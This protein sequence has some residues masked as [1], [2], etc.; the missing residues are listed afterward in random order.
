MAEDRYLQNRQKVYDLLKTEG[1]T[2]EELGGSAENLFKDKSNGE[3]AYKALTDAGYDDLGEYSDFQSMLFAP[4]NEAE[5]ATPS[6]PAPEAEGD[7]NFD[8]EPNGLKE[9]RAREERLARQQA[10][11]EG[12]DMFNDMRQRKAQ[13]AVEQAP[14]SSVEDAP[15]ETRQKYA[16][17]EAAIKDFGRIS[18]EIDGFDQRLAAFNEKSDQVSSGK[19]KLSQDEFKKMQDEGKALADIA[20]RYDTVMSSAEGQEYKA[21]SERM[22]EIAKGEKTPESAWEYAQE[23][24]KLQRNPVFRAAQGENAA[25]EDEINAGLLQGQIAYLDEKMKSAKGNE[26][27][28]LKKAFSDAKEALYANP[29]YRKEIEGKIAENKLE[30]EQIGAQ[31]AAF[32][33]Q[34]R[35]GYA[36]Q[37]IDPNYYWQMEKGEPELQR[38]DAAARMHDDAIREYEKPT[39]YEDY[40]KNVGKGL[41]DWASNPDTYSFGLQSFADD[42]AVVRPVLEK[43]EKIAGSV[44]EDAIM[45][46]GAIDSLEKQLTPGELAVLDA[47]FEKVG[48]VAAKGADTAIGYQIGQGIGDM[49][50]LGLEMIA[51]SG[52]GTAVRKGIDK[53]GMSMMKRMMGKRLYR[54][55]AKSGAGRVALWGT[56]KI[57]RDIAETAV[58]MP[59]MPSTYKNLGEKAVTLDEGYKT[60]SFKEYA[61][62]AAWDQFVEQLTEVS[63]GFAFPLMGKVV[64][65]PG[66]QKLFKETIGE[67]GVR[68]LRSFMERGDIKLLDDAML[69]SF[70]GEWEEEL[71]GAVIHS[72]TDDP[73]ALSDFFSAEQQLVLLGT[74]APLPISRGAVGGVQ[75]AVPTANA[76]YRW[77]RAEAELKRLGLDEG[78]ISRLK[79]VIDNAPVPEAAREVMN[80][81][82]D[83]YEGMWEAEDAAE[84]DILH[85]TLRAADVGPSSRD[86]D[87]NSR[88]I[89]GELARYFWAAQQKRAAGLMGEIQADQKVA[90]K[91]TELEQNLGGTFYH[92]LNGEDVVEIGTLTAP[93]G[94]TRNIYITSE[95]VNS[96]GELAYVGEDGSKGFVNPNELGDSRVIPVDRYLAGLVMQDAQEQEA[97]GV[98]N[99]AVAVNQSLR[100]QVESLEEVTYQGQTGTISRASSSDEAAVFIPD[101]GENVVVPWEELASQNGIPVPEIVTQEENAALG[102]DAVVQR[103]A[104]QQQIADAFHEAYSSANRPGAFIDTDE[105]RMAV[106]DIIED[107][108]NPEDG[109]AEFTVRQP[110]GTRNVTMRTSI[111]RVM[112][113]LQGQPVPAEEPAPAPAEEPVAEQPAE[114]PEE[115]APKIPVDKNGEKI[116]DAPGVSVE[117]AL[118]DIY[119][120]EGITEEMADEYIRD[121]AAEAEKGRNPKRGKMNLAEWGKATAEANRK[122]DFWKEMR[123]FADAN[124]AEREREQKEEAERQERI[125]QY[126]VDPATFDMTPQT[127]EEA[128]AEYLGNSEKLIDLDDAIR[129]TLG[130]RKDNRVPRELFRHLGNGGILVKNGG[131]SVQD[132]A[133]DI[134][135]EYE[136]TLA[137]TQDDV[138]TAI[139]DALL[140]KTKTEMRETIFNN[141]LEEARNAAEAAEA[142]PVEEPAPAPVV[143]EPEPEPTP[144][145]EPQ[146]EPVSEP[147]APAEE[148]AE[149]PVEEPEPAE[150]ETTE[151]PENKPDKGRKSG[152]K[153]VSLN[154]P[155]SPSEITS[156]EEARAYFENL[157]GKGKRADNSVRVWELTHKKKSAPANTEGE[158]SRMAMS[159]V[160]ESG[161]S[162]EEASELVTLGTQLAEDYITE[163][164]LVKFPQFFKNL[165]ETFGDGIRP[166]SKQIYLG[167]SA[168]VSDELADQMDD[169]KAVRAFDTSIDL[170]E[171]SDEQDITDIREGEQPVEDMVGDS[172]EGAG[173]E[174]VTDGSDGD[175]TGDTGEDSTP[176]GSESADSEG[177]VGEV[178]G[179][180]GNPG[181]SDYAPGN[182]EGDN[183]GA[184]DRGGSRRG[185]KR[186]GGRR[187]RTSE[188]VGESEPGLGRDTDRVEDTEAAA[189]EAEQKAYDEEKESIKEETDT[190]KLKSRKDDLK[191]K[192]SAIAEKV[193][194]EKAKLSGQLRAVIERLRELFSTSAKKS[195]ALAQE[196]VPYSSASDP[197][198]EHAIGSVVPSGSADAMRDAIRRLEAEEG[199]SVAE[200]VKDELGYASLDEMFSSET[201]NE[202]LSA[203]QVDSVGLAIHQMKKGKMFIIGDMTGIGKGRQGAALIR[204]SKRQG[205]K[206]LFV[207]EKPD[208]FSD[209][210][211]DLADI[212]TK[213][214]L[215]WIVNSDSGANITD[216]NSEDK[217]VL[218]K[219]PGKAESDSLY[220]SDSD[221]L[222]TVK[223]GLYKGKQYDFVM[224]TYSQAQ[225]A[226]TTAAER[227][228]DWIKKYAKDAIV[229]CDESHNASGD[230]NRGKYFQDIVKN[231]QGVTFSSATFAKR[232]DNMV[233][234]ALRSSIGDAQMTQEDMIKA[235]QQYGIPMQEI[236][237]ASLFKTGEMVRRERDF[238]D[239]KTHW[240]EPKEIYSEEE[241]GRSRQTFDKSI[242]VVNDIIDFQRRVVD[243]IIKKKNEDEFK[244]KNEL[245]A[246]ALATT[247]EGTFYEYTTTP[248]S[249]QVS[250]VA[251][252]MFY[253]IKA[254]KAADMAIEQIKKGEKPVIAVENTLESY[255]KDIDGDVKSADFAFVLNRGLNTALK[256]RLKV[257]T[258]RF[259]P[260]TK[261]IEVVKEKSY[262]KELGS[263]EPYFGEPAQASLDAVKASLEQYSEDK[264]VMP[265]MLSPIDYIKKRIEDAGYK[266]GEITGRS[267]QLVQAPDG[268]WH[269]EPYKTDKK[270]AISQF[271]G[272]ETDALILNT[273][274]STGISLH[275][276]RR[277]KDQKKRN[278]IILQPA[279]DPNT[280]VQIRG[281]VDRTG[282]VSRAEYFY[283]TSPIPAEQKVIMMLRQKLASLDANSVGTENVSSN[284]VNADDMDNKYGD[285][286]ARQFL[287][288][289][290]EINDQLD[291]PLQEKKG[292]YEHR[293]GLLYQLLIGI[294]RMTCEEQEMILGELQSAYRDQIEY[295]NQNGIND[296]ATTTMNL[297]AVTIDKGLFIKGKDNESMS[298][299]AHDT[300]IE[301]VEVNVLNKPLR[302][303]DINA[304]MKKLGALTEDGKI[305]SEYGT[306]MVDLARAYIAKAKEERQAK[307]AAA[308]RKLEQ[309]LREQYPKPELQSEAD[310]EK[311]I[312]SMP[313]YAALL[314]K[315]Q[316]DYERFSAELDRQSRGVF[317][318]ARY[319]KPGMPMLVP[320]T[321]DVKENA[322]MSYGRF[323]GF[324]I[325]KDGKPK[326]I[327]AV[328]AV[329]DSRASIEIPIISKGD[330]MQS[331]ID[332]TYGSFG[333]GGTN[334]RD[335]GGPA[336]DSSITDEDRR[337][338]RDEWWDK[339]IPKDTNR[340]IRYMVTGNILQACGSLGK[341]KGTITTF[342]R[343]DP[344]TGEITVERGMLLAED[345]DPENFEVRSAVTKEDVWDGYDQ[346]KDEITNI[347]VRREGDKMIVTFDRK[348][349]EKLANHPIMK[350]DGFKA[351][352]DGGEI[353]PYSRDQLRAYVSEGNVEAVLDYLYKNYSFTKGHQFVMPDSTE[354]V[355]AI[356]YTD[357]PYKDVIDEFGTKYNASE[358][359]VESRIKKAVQQY[360]M[361]VNNE[362]LKTKI[363]EL[364]QLRQAYYRK[365]YAKDESSRL[366][367]NV[368]IYDQRIEQA[369]DD[370]DMRDEAYAIR[371]AIKEELAERGV[372]GNAMH[373]ESGKVPIDTIIKTFNDLN[374]NKANADLAKRIFA[375]VKKLKLDVIFNEKIHN[376][377]GGQTAGQ[378]V[379]YNWKYMNAE[380]ITDQMKADTILHELVHT[381]T[382]Y[383]KRLVDG[384]YEHLINQD[385]V[386]AVQQLD[387]IYRQIR[388][389]KNFTHQINENGD[390]YTDY[391]VQ[392]W[393]EMM[394]EAGSNENFRDD[395]KRTTLGVKV[396]SGIISF[397]DVTN[398]TDYTGKTQSAYDAIKERLDVLIDNFSEHGFT[399]FFRGSM[400]GER[401]Y[402]E[403]YRSGENLFNPIDRARA[404]TTIDGIAKK[405]GVE[406][407]QDSSLNA[408]GAFNP[409]TGKIR[410][411]IDAHKDTAD[412][413]ATLLHEA[414]AHYG[415]RKLFGKDWRALRSRLYEQASPEIKAKVD[416]IAKAD[417]LSTEVAMEEYIAQ[418]AEDGRF[419]AQE[420]SFWQRIV[421]AIKRLLAKIGV[422]AGYLTD[423]DFRA[424]LYASYRNLE[425]RGAIEQAQ[426]VAAYRA[427]RMSADLSR[428]NANFV[429]NRR[430]DR[431]RTSKSA[432]DLL[433]REDDL[434]GVS[435]GVPG[436][437]E[438]LERNEDFRGI[439][440]LEERLRVL[441]GELGGGRESADGGRADDNRD[442]GGGAELENRREAISNALIEAAKESGQYIDYSEIRK[443]RKDL[444]FGHTMES[445]VYYDAENDR[446][447][448]VRNPFASARLTGND[449]F[450]ILFH[451]IIHN[452]YFPTERYEFLGITQVPYARYASIVLAQKSAGKNAKPSTWKD[453]HKWYKD[454]G[455]VDGGIDQRCV[456]WF[457]KDGILVCDLGSK[458]LLVDANGELHPIDPIIRF[459]DDPLDIIG[460]EDDMLNRNLSD[461]PEETRDLAVE[462]ETGE[463]YRRARSNATALTAAEAYNSNVRTVRQALHEVVVDEYAPVDTLVKA[464]ADESGRKIKDNERV[465]DHLREVGGKAMGAIRSYNEKFL[466]PMWDA[467][468]SFRKAAGDISIEDT[469][470]YIGL[471]SGLERNEVFAKR[472]AK[473][474]Y[475]QQYE[476]AID[477]INAEEKEK[478][479]ALDK[480]LKTGAISDVTY[481]GELT[482]LQQEMN[483]KRDQAAA[484]RDAHIA[485]VDAGTDERYAEYR[486][487]D[488][489]AITAWAET[490]DVAAA[491]QAASDFVNDMEQRAGASVVKEMWKRINAATKETLKFQYE[492]D[493][494]TRDQYRDISKMLNYYVPMRGFAEDTAEDLFN[495]YVTAQSNDFQP[496]ILSA[497]G[498]HTMYEGPLGNIGAMHSSA[499]SQGMKNQAKLSLLNLVRNRKG[500]TIATITRA[501]FVK[502]GQKD[503]AGKDIYEVAYPDVPENATFQQRQSIIEQFEED[504]KQLKAQGDAYNAHREVDLH[505][506]VVAFEKESHKNEHIVQVREGGK[507]YGIIINGNPA[508]AQAING[509]RRGNGAG[510][511]FLG[512][513]RNWTRML[514]QMFTT[515]SVP[516]WV[517]NFQ[518]DFGQGLTNTFIRNDK[519]YFGKYLVNYARAFKVFPL[520]IG[521]NTMDNAL[522]KGDSVAQLYQQYL[523]N[524]GPMG[525]TRLEDNEYFERQ[526]KRYLD[527]S[528][529]TG[530]IKGATG[531]LEAIG[532]V[533]EAVE[534]VTRFAV[535]MTSMQ[536]GRPLH[537]SIADAK[538][539]ST[540]FARKGSGR[541]FTKDELD[542]MRRADGRPLNS[543]EK[544]FVNAVSI[545]VEIF[546]ATVPFFN[547]A[548][549][550]LE[551]KGV[552]YSGNF[553]KTL[554]ADSIYFMA[555]LG[556]MLLR[557]DDGGDDDKEKYSHTS[558]YLRRNN[559]LFGLGDGLYAKWALPQEYR[560]CYA[561]GDIVGSAIKQQRPIDDLAIDAFGALMQLSPTGVISDEVLFSAGDKQKAWENL[562]VGISPGVVAPVFEAIFNRD[563]KGARL[564]N[565][566]FN[567]NNR[568]YPGWTK[569]LNTTGEEYVKAAETL[570]KLQRNSIEGLHIADDAQNRVERGLVNLNPA[571]VEHLVESYFSG[572]YQII[573]RT[574]EAIGKAVGGE[575]KVR[576]I[577][578]LNRLLL[579]A[580][581]NKRD[582]YY[583]NMYYYFK[584]LDTEASRIYSEYLKT[585]PAHAKEMMGTKDYQYMLIFK[586][587]DMKEKLYRKRGKTAENEG[588]I[589]TKNQ[590]DE[591]IQSLHEQIAKEC[592]DIYFGRQEV[593]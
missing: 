288:D 378:L 328:F 322:P 478:K 174:S 330:V 426:R 179:D 142:A 269:T 76:A 449:D 347:G 53:A 283:I 301:R 335:I 113:G 214:L 240:Y 57:G 432:N 264:E 118:E 99:E 25:S 285:E 88:R 310:Y 233:L 267:L 491:E 5:Q 593:K 442:Y 70:G 574:P 417:G 69:G 308:E 255:L 520:I 504:M 208:L 182:G 377:V 493:M 84:N 309:E 546:R 11:S 573:V 218:V 128:V 539:V 494:L 213:D 466:R 314:A 532:R 339:M 453:M 357:K 259:N 373:F 349:R 355:D 181:E 287:I 110:D 40:D 188:P 457:K 112:A 224:M 260:E 210:Y 160:S 133:N 321:D 455:F 38:L 437:A 34:L 77:N 467:V 500:N 50:T 436:Y 461:L 63:N 399:E 232:P 552:N 122:A 107:T 529:K 550:G 578:L 119:T 366:A 317:N 290:P 138:R 411:N 277:F 353:D 90:A 72:V 238:S 60:R 501:W 1:Y 511:R 6:T 571:I 384:G 344:D 381:V 480:Q 418:L 579:N 531:V 352:I 78:R 506:G 447:I 430:N 350:D 200:F 469:E 397:S 420:E 313:Q 348:G 488:Y 183:G 458:N 306:K 244:E 401:S 212:G 474:D 363:R 80:A 522:A 412:L 68:A 250:N 73:K 415:L 410:I 276:S 395:L 253:S 42:V 342:T 155:G 137:I 540:N 398:R 376:S 503:A 487:K 372:H 434:R 286:I 14:T 43:V 515:F 273:A 390:S 483:D 82:R 173:E 197:T 386:D 49:V 295:L 499:I 549:Q 460:P 451:H 105:G 452:L 52:A 37:G 293:E 36:E 375:L 393:F 144:E 64:K 538:E 462:Q 278:M 291:K 164:G 338:A 541:S 391:G 16:D 148:P 175:N 302:S 431:E 86:Y 445:D 396:M 96:N 561:L 178:S 492:H 257:T 223:R 56:H 251:G 558:D 334:L 590:M 296:L 428:N 507:E 2:D 575:A 472:D 39:K 45:T 454:N 30:N 189:A 279:R 4:D 425:T 323:I 528:V 111:E 195:E 298:E 292:E 116:Y 172:G 187:G 125:K 389:N 419:D 496:T 475:Q 388:Y 130:R 123:E 476:D 198:G 555:G 270:K 247:G 407:E 149:E 171:I 446:Y 265:L 103:M 581:D 3:L 382:A 441:R 299:F 92:P 24:A 95:Q 351:L 340:Q 74:L 580:N 336:Y 333:F 106:I 281:R 151:S 18:Q 254:Q 20:K 542:R 572:P 473:R 44:N 527:N 305:D 41:A 543:V 217:T 318:I 562:V 589:E 456:Q 369:K 272:G 71:L 536:S 450:D 236:L 231:A 9:T 337:P 421:A 161:L 252:L 300:N 358:W 312:L 66:M 230:S 274:G 219:H 114:E 226:R 165:V 440:N 364:V 371:E 158:V 147:E 392:D 61:P 582:A 262:V 329:K 533:G 221:E 241:L 486:K 167:A 303:S 154:V 530:I 280:E 497:K 8:D 569:A 537:Q 484:I 248:Y 405:L 294:Q 166:F 470:T 23:Y 489:S 402:N 325:P 211:Q 169:R 235:I 136:G 162:E 359:T 584:G 514:S 518:R 191:S 108:I 229:I 216:K 234:Y 406:F 413:E 266:C 101:D 194:I 79:E 177:A 81:Y 176:G 324:K 94:S 414:V 468:A 159:L 256:H 332:N 367:W 21:V 548:V 146:P 534:T 327:K 139:I 404:I 163:D 481:Q 565:E 362:D 559:I 464:I 512:I 33:Q 490:D 59:F 192:I 121:M 54:K 374:K 380:W 319:C 311:A 361:D 429:E 370:K 379:E 258:K 586:K 153:P 556:M 345:F 109:T 424:M 220:K 249:G 341:Y 134:V 551:N 567:D 237:A 186:N 29:Y 331:V 15:A 204:W 132:V 365:R 135:G 246:A 104:E 17:E 315:N 10:V 482:L 544:G 58:R 564:Y 199:K 85:G 320:L 326:G 495:Y 7:L 427:L 521:K 13:K 228:L 423:E 583:S 263:V 206:V 209:M 207:T 356:V 479:K 201:K 587:N 190:N 304:R 289:H 525:Q 205:K 152:E 87:E 51:T 32:V 120:T 576:D 193:N 545:G 568:L 477:G 143:E 168:N 563:F 127:V 585:S 485:D 519:E 284:R 383:A 140:G 517:S 47:Y 463:L 55:F 316:S 28:E 409:K 91:R 394:A 97:E 184:N 354:R 27:K 271:N 513:M 67:N 239:V 524:G 222:P 526:M 554:L 282:Q 215:P 435:G 31:R 75:L 117:D 242:G 126:G 131:R 185:T 523:E 346:I 509:V 243:P 471:K 508:A 510:E 360:K 560:V 588:D 268:T 547:A 535:F 465:S 22:N 203:E 275:A 591:K 102:A 566:G 444:V 343:K 368:I 26:K 443:R 100:Q 400:F 180:S 124:T 170:S 416:A 141:R 422:N 202:G 403:L 297:E 150:E 448:K 225:G 129:E 408:K 385:I 35:A 498:R 553:G 438:G 577:P 433:G 83:T 502:T 557:S 157:Y 145:P 505:G 89:Y 196:K 98:I 19:L 46:D 48:A 592:L 261:Q 65:T 387:N 570:N 227:K 93:D 245:A 12:T 156:K 62:E 516:F 307:H 439:R 459:V 115:E